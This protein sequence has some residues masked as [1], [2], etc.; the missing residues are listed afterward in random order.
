M[1]RSLFD[2]EDSPEEEKKEEAKPTGQAPEE[3][4]AA[5]API[6]LPAS[7]MESSPSAEVGETSSEEK[8]ESAENVFAADPEPAPVISDSAEPDSDQAFLELERKVAEIEE[9]IRASD[10]EEPEVSTID[11]VDP[12]PETPNEFEPAETVSSEDFSE[13]TPPAPE[14]VNGINVQEATDRDMETPVLKA[15]SKGGF[16]KIGAEPDETPAESAASQVEPIEE[17]AIVRTDPQTDQPVSE[18]TALSPAVVK[19]PPSVPFSE[20]E[21]GSKLEAIRQ[22]GL[23]WTAATVLFGSIAFLLILGW[24]ADLLLGTS[25][26]GAVGG[27]IIGSILGFFQFFRLTSQILKDR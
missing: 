23:A 25:P 20:P 22:S 10:S 12:L 18:S 27:I 11:S 8:G 2:T 6:E 19:T 17:P 13:Q 21:P 26:W 1:I 4:A 5:P 15:L 16:Q 24:F 3:T 14:N 9:E 7:E